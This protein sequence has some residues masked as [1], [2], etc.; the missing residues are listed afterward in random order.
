MLLIATLIPLILGGVLVA[1]IYILI[2]ESIKQSAPQKTQ[3]LQLNQYSSSAAAAK[4]QA[5]LLK[6]AHGDRAV[7]SRLIEGVRRNNPNRSTEWC[8]E[9][10]I[11]DL[12]RDRH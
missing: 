12:E 10:A 7:V 1:S 11:H 9:K 5:E 3:H 2:R 4:L 8:I 6:L